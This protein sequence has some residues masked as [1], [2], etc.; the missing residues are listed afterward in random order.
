[1]ETG[2]PT[3]DLCLFDK[4]VV[5]LREDL[6]EVCPRL[7]CGRFLLPLLE[8]HGVQSFLVNIVIGFLDYFLGGEV[9]LSVLCEIYFIFHMLKSDINRPANLYR[10]CQGL[11]ASLE[12]RCPNIP[13]PLHEVI[14]EV[15]CCDVVEPH[16]PPVSLW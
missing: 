3:C 10:F 11:S 14:Y 4:V 6:I 12:I 16:V 5:L 1:M 8:I 7:I 15:L 2:V 13:I 9:C